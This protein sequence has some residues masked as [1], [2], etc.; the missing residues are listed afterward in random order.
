MTHDS[1][2]KHTPIAKITESELPHNKAK[3]LD[4]AGVV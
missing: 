4:A 3:P 1:Q 2:I